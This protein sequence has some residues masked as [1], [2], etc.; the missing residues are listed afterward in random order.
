M[1][2]EKLP[3]ILGY[4][5]PGGRVGIRNHVAIVY[6]TNCAKVVARKLYDCFPVGTQLFGYPEGCS[7]RDAPVEKIVAMAQHASYEADLV[8]GL[9]C[10][11]TDAGDLARRFRFPS[12]SSGQSAAG[13]TRPQASSPTLSSAEL[14]IG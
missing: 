11:G 7:Y 10:E 6:T 13:P 3:E 14:P 12:P 1:P 8:V 9:G 4:R 2:T 5:R